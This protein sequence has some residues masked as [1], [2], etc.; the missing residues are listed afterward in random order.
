[1]PK[2]EK[3]YRREVANG[4]IMIPAVKVIEEVR[5]IVLRSHRKH[6]AAQTAGRYSKADQ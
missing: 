6:H 5:E 4:K 1:M 2:L 3:K